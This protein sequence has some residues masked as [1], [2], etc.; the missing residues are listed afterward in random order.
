MPDKR[1][2]DRKAKGDFHVKQ[3]LEKGIE[4]TGI[5]RGFSSADLLKVSEAALALLQ[6]TA[7]RGK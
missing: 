3:A 4:S 1:I 7:E 6:R 5:Q 2:R